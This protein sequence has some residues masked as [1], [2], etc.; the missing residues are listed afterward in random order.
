MAVLLRLFAMLTSV[1]FML[2]GSQ[3]SVVGFTEGE[4]LMPERQEYCFDR[5]RLLIGAYYGDQKKVKEAKEAGIEFFI[6]SGITEEYLDE[7]EKYGIGIIASD[8]NLPRGYANF[9]DSLRDGWVNFDYENEY[10]DHPAL[11]G[12]DLIDEPNVQAYANIAES[13]DA[14][15]ENTD[16]KIP[17]VNLFP[18][19]ASDEQLG[20]SPERTAAQKFFLAANNN[21][22][23][24]GPSYKTYVSEYINTIGTDYISVDIYPYSSKLNIR[25]REVKDT[26]KSWLRNLDILAE[27]CRDTNRDL[28]V[29]T[30]ASGE[31][32]HGE[33]DGGPR[34]CDEVSD[35]SQQAY[36]SLAFGAKA[37]I[38]A[39]FGAKGWWDPETSH[40]IDKDGNT[41]KTYDAV[42]TVDGYLSAFAGEY[43]KYTYTGTYM[44]NPLSVAGHDGSAL[45]TTVPS[46]AIRLVSPNGLLIGTFRGENKRAFIIVNMEELNKEKTAEFI[47]Q[48]PDG[49]SFTVYR[50]GAAITYTGG[51]A[52]H[53][54]LKPGEGVFA[55]MPD[56]GGC[57]V[58]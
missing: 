44:M 14:Y 29:I 56:A 54:V 39:E 7:C 22:T 46:E 13:V 48:V 6:D 10:K 19:Y 51:S 47:Y 57:T 30:Q 24:A 17:L 37:I 1:L 33:D 5:D 23:G 18:S 32:E 31:T 55:T 15:L 3:E 36:A 4:V 34:Y 49:G 40:M 21:G 11:W 26:N 8:Y 27:A 25:G 2:A 20:V 35:I 41:T 9:P 50:R 45:A 16:G 58:C 38:H 43:G 53:I 42:K 52:A 28:W 12:D